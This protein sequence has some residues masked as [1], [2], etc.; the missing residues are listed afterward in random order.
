MAQLMD[1]PGSADADANPHLPFHLAPERLQVGLDH[2]RSA[3]ADAGP[4]V[5]VLRRPGEGRREL[6]DE[7]ALDPVDGLVGD[8]WRERGSRS[9]ADGSADPERQLTI[10]NARVAALVAGDDERV[11]LA[12]DQVYVDLDL[13]HDN[14]PAGTR[15]ALGTAVVEVSEPP[16]TGCAK[17]SRRFGREALRMVNAPEGRAGRY[18]GLNARIVEA[19]VVRPGDIVR[20]LP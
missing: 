16:H 7:A 20:K 6:L 18:R 1:D 4:V 10:M 9:T 12:G 3:P 8:T 15:L 17:F 14:L 11:P 19:G 2:V 13:S 5:L